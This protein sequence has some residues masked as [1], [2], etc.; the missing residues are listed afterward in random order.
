MKY[1]IVA[2]L[3]FTL[4]SVN[5]QS[6]SFEE[7]LSIREMDSVALSALSLEKGYKFSGNKT[8]NGSVYQYYDGATTYL[9]RSYPLNE[10]GD[11]IVWYYFEDKDTLQ[12]FKK[13]ARRSGFRF[14]RINYKYDGAN[15][16]TH[17]IFTNGNSELS[18]AS[19]K[20]DDDKP[21]YILTLYRRSD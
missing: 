3:L 20:T 11:R 17:Q 10:D 1:L 8:E 2:A 4:K 21:L 6:L 12:A 7:I 19:S 5:A 14:S 9:I 16:V 15:K 18:L 13:Q